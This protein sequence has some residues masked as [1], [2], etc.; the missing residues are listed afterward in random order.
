[1]GVINVL[2][3]LQIATEFQKRATLGENGYSL[4]DV[5]LWVDSDVIFHCDD[6]P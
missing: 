3:I 5:H 6:T 1:L 4:G 2:L